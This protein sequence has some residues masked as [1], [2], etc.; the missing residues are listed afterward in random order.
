MGENEALILL[1]FGLGCIC[2]AA[3]VTRIVLA[4]YRVLAILIRR[5]PLSVWSL[6]CDQTSCMI[7][8]SGFS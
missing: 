5:C 8:W 2:G 6:E 4:Y 1:G 7:N 3:V